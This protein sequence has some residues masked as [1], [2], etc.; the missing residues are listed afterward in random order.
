ME[1][2]DS[3][4]T[5]GIIL[6]L[7]VGKLVGISVFSFAAVKSGM[8]DLPRGVTWSQVVGASCLAGIGFTMSLFVTDLAF[9]NPEDD[10]LRSSAKVGILAASLVA[11]TIG[12]VI[13][14]RN[15]N[16]EILG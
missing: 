3:R 1:G 8:T 13:L 5:L 14:S 2:L 4:V 9:G 12:C 11:G 15:R 7:V 16:R 10:L 6:G